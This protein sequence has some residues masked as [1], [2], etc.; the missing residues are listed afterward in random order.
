MEFDI[1][2]GMDS[3]A[4]TAAFA[5][6]AEKM[7]ASGLLFTES[8]QTPWMMIA[9]AAMAAPDLHYSTGIAVAFPRSPMVAAQIAWELAGETRGKFRLGL[10][11]QVKPHI[12]R[13]YG[14]TFDKPAMRMRDYVL[15]VKASLRAFR[16]DERLAHDG[17]FYKL[18]LLTPHWTP[19]R[20]DFEDVKV[21]MSAVNPLMLKVAGE[22]SDGVHV[23]P[24]H[25]M[26]YIEN[27][28]IPAVSEG[29]AKAGKTLSDVD[30]I[31]PVMAVAGDTPEERDALAREAKSAIGFYGST[32][33]YG[34]QFDDL[35]YGDLRPK[36]AERLRAQGRDGLIELISDEM[37]DQFGLVARW[38]DMA[39][40][41][42]ARYRGVASRV[43]MYL[44]KPSIEQNPKNLGKWG[45]IARAVRAAKLKAFRT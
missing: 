2:A 19:A 33:G 21:D 37:L 12:V 10:G 29:A 27:R 22:V 15:A 41:L 14:G 44:A 31:V 24:M 42:I 40:N 28:V 7:G 16:G 32:P 34:F 8:G 18:D 11:S 1:K 30:L 38:D 9:A 35:G 45:E 3:W 4:D 20:H 13:R 43:V 6:D 25:S 36:L 26:H 23:H 17:P 39:D 5:R